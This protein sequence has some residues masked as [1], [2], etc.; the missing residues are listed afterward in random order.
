MAI[1]RYV[2]VAGIDGNIEKQIQPAVEVYKFVIDN[3]VFVSLLTLEDSILQSKPYY[4]PLKE[5]WFVPTDVGTINR[6]SQHS[7]VISRYDDG[8]AALDGIESTSTIQLVAPTAVSSSDWEDGTPE[9]D[10]TVWF[11]G[12][13]PVSVEGGSVAE[14]PVY[15]GFAPESVENNEHLLAKIIWV[16]DVPFSYVA[17]F[18]AGANVAYLNPEE[19]LPTTGTWHHFISG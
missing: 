6:G 16:S 11:S 8:T 15:V 10:V 4:G 1:G 17:F 7:L 2:E 12:T 19:A 9:V 5:T 3:A 14:H 18:S 13:F